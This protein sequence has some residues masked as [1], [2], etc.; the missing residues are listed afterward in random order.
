MEIKKEPAAEEDKHKF[1]I[2][3]SIKEEICFDNLS[4][5]LSSDDD[6]F[7]D[8]TEEE[9]LDDFPIL[10]TD[11][12]ESLPLQAI[13]TEKKVKEKEQKKSKEK[14]K[15]DTVDPLKDIKVSELYLYLRWKAY[16][17]YLAK[18]NITQY[19]ENLYN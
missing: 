10:S 8:S 2:E 15:K 3:G 19:P 13:N 1:K 9:F 18:M 14:K 4:L 17:S 7:E 5:L 16:L 6:E 11:D 12:D